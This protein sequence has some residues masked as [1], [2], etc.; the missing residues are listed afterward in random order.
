MHVD[1]QLCCAKAV[2]AAQ[3]VIHMHMF[4]ELLHEPS[5]RSYDTVATYPIAEAL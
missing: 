2:C 1:D 5:V 3:L 4:F